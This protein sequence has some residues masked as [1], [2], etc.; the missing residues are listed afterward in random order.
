MDPD[1]EAAWIAA[2]T[3]V[4]EGVVRLVIEA[5]A[6]YFVAIGLCEADDVIAAYGDVGDG[7]D[8]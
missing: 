3:G 2:F 1:D 7:R 6:H 5:Q 8:S 4:D